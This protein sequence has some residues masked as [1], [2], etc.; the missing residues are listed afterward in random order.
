M[1]D[2]KPTYEE[3]V[4]Y[5]KNEGLIGKVDTVKFYDFYNKQGFMYRGAIM[6][7]K[8]KLHEWASSQRARVMQS[9]KEAEAIRAMGKKIDT[10][11]LETI[12]NILKGMALA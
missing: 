11:Q 9:A 3:V 7:W 5:A 4:A 1:T 10:Q 8:K 12:Q 6:D 2:N